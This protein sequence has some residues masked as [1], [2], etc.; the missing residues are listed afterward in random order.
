MTVSFRCPNCGKRLKADAKRAGRKSTCPKCASSVKIPASSEEAAEG[1]APEEETSGGHGMLLVRTSSKHHED[2]IDMTA[3]V[4]IV[5]FLLIFFMT[6]S[7]QP[8]ES[9]IGLPTPKAESSSAV[10]M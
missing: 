4:D 3:M 10:S 5:F 7:M 6:T 9:V 8:V 1:A 2:L